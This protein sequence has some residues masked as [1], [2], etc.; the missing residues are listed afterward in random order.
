[1]HMENDRKKYFLRSPVEYRI[2]LLIDTFSEMA[3][4][5]KSSKIDINNHV[6]GISYQICSDQL[7]D[8]L[9]K[10]KRDDNHQITVLKNAENMKMF[11]MISD[12]LLN[13]T[14]KT[15]PKKSKE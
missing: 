15:K 11:G 14:N 1:M 6:V 5:Y 9:T 3:K 12:E 7:Q 4:E 2:Q 13:G 8:L 10:I